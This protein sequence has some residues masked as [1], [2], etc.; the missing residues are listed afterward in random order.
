ME[1]DSKNAQRIPIITPQETAI[2]IHSSNSIMKPIMSMEST[3]IES[4]P[5]VA[6]HESQP[7]NTSQ[8]TAII[9]DTSTSTSTIN[10]KPIIYL[11]VGPLKTA[12]TTIQWV[13]K[14]QCVRTAALE[15]DNMILLTSDD[16]PDELNKCINNKFRASE[17]C[18]QYLNDIFQKFRGENKTL[19]L[20]H[21]RISSFNEIESWKFWREAL[22]NWDVHIIVVYRRTYEWELSLFNQ[23]YKLDHMTF[24]KW[25]ST[26]LEIQ[27]LRQVFDSTIS[28][29]NIRLRRPSNIYNFFL[30][31]GHRVEVMNMHAEGDVV[32]D[33]F[34]KHIKRANATCAAVIDL[35]KN[36]RLPRKNQS[37]YQGYDRIAIAAYRMGLVNKSIRRS[38][39]R[40]R[41]Q[42]RHEVELGLESSSFP[43]DCVSSKDLDKVLYLTIQEEKMIFPV[44][45]ESILGE[46]RLRH[47]F[48]TAIN[49]GK[50]CNVDGEKV[51]ADQGWIDFFT[52]LTEGESDVA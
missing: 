14:Q 12:S 35:N 26:K 11:H 3:H 20:S 22:I 38:F 24:D 51:L 41:I 27:N 43:V 47:N 25:K 45:S 2:D 42:M 48:Q 28:K 39:V 49:K 32:K 5:K 21:E 52:N 36:I 15:K 4:E 40:S 31:S 7:I 44:F 8:E 37:V 1:P 18:S 19:F 29:K 34:C 6:Q 16:L 50:F 13:A 46:E 23:R 33:L 30:K 10:A 17:Y 9:S